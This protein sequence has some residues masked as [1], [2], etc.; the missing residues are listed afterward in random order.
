MKDA[1][2]DLKPVR[3]VAPAGPILTLAEAKA[4]LRVDHDDDDALITAIVQAA[5]DHVDGYAGILGRALVS[6][7]WRMNIE[8]WPARIRLPLAPVSAITSVKYYDTAN[9]QQTLDGSNYALLDDAL[10]P[11]IVWT[12]TASLPPIF[13]REDAIEVL[14]VAGYGGAASDVPQPIRHAALLLAG[15][16]YESR[17]TFVVGETVATLPFAAMS[18]LAPFRRTGS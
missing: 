13:D 16:L 4:H 10:S 12:G 7:T 8:C 11:L 15:N 1:L 9:A 5:T 3:T 18:L 14:F 2:Y 6:Q 17:E